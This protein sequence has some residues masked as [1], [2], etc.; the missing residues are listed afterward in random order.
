M[1]DVPSP[2]P[3]YGPWGTPF[4][5]PATAEDLGPGQPGTTLFALLKGILLIL[6]AMKDDA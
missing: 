1:A 4:D 2:N 5:P 3:V 6:S